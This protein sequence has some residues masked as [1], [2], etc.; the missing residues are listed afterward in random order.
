MY[1]IVLSCK[2]LHNTTKYLGKWPVLL[3]KLRVKKFP[4]TLPGSPGQ[5]AMAVTARE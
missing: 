4:R 1:F 3:K 5:Q 2:E